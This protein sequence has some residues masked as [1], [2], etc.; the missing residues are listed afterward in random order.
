MYKFSRGIF[1]V[2]VI[3]VHF[4]KIPATKYKGREENRK[5]WQRERRKVKKKINKIK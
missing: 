5:I 2:E 3:V 1:E 4:Y